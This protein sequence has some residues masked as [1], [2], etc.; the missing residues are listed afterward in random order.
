MMFSKANERG[1]IR[2]NSINDSKNS[3]NDSKN[4]I[5]NSQ[6]SVNDSN[7]VIAMLMIVIVTR[8]A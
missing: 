2:D 3:A 7:L 6:N 1:D 8:I 4:S 5:N